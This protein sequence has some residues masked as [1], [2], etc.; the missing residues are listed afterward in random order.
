MELLN[1]L[2]QEELA[3]KQEACRNERVERV[4]AEREMNNEIQNKSFDE[5]TPEEKEGIIDKANKQSRNKLKKQAM[6]L[7]FCDADR[8]LYFQEPFFPDKSV[9][10]QSEFYARGGDVVYQDLV[11]QS[12]TTYEFLKNKDIARYDFFESIAAT[13]T[14]KSMEKPDMDI[15]EVEALTRIQ[16]RFNRMKDRSI[17][18]LHRLRRAPIQINVR[19]NNVNF[20]QQTSNSHTENQSEA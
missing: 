4:L 3:Q 2:T 1:D 7:G 11:K 6:M 14:A 16:E 12:E 17:N 13:K 15:K 18:T 5:L 10:I 8:P 9:D 20:G 19:G